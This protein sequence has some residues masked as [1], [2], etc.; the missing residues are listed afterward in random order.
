[1]VGQ[2]RNSNQI[3]LDKRNRLS[4]AITPANTTD[5]ASTC[6]HPLHSRARERLQDKGEQGSGGHSDEAGA[7]LDSTGS[8]DG[9]AAGI[10]R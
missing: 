10:S 1:M 5:G 4:F 3:Q 2:K 8:G 9:S 6:A 7:S